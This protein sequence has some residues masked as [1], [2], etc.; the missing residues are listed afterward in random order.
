MPNINPETTQLLEFFDRKA[1]LAAM[2]A[3]SFPIDFSYPE[4]V[5][6]LKRLGFKYVVEVAAGAMETNKQLTALLKAN[7]NKRYIASPCPNIVRLIR[8]KYPQL[9]RFLTPIDSP[10]AATAKIV[11]KKYPGCKKVFIGPCLVKKLEAKEDRPEPDILVLTYKDI[12]EVFKIKNILP[13]KKDKTAAFDISGSQTRLYPISGGLAQSSCL[14]KNLV[15]EEYDVI[16]GPK[17]AAKAL[18]EFADKSELKVL[19]ILNCEGGCVNGPGVMSADS[20]AA[21]RQ[22][23]IAYWNRQ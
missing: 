12:A 10:M 1:K 22:K 4:I 20:L 13:D 18:A 16:S 6:M 23:I 2:L 8:N 11:D 17:Q 21:R 19:D 15:D 9:V 14:T 3:P 7:P 5:G